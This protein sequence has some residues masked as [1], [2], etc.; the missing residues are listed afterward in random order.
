V[1]WNTVC[2]KKEVGGLG[3][4]R[5]R[6]F[7]NVLLGKWCWRLLTEKNSL[8]YRVLTGRY[9]EEGGCVLDGGRDASA[10]WRVIA[11]LQREPWFSNHVCRVV[12]DGKQTYFWSDVWVGGVSFKDRFSRLFELAVDKWVFVFDLC[13]LGWGVN[14]E[15][16]KWRQRLFAWEEEKVGELCLLL[17]YVNLQVNK[18]DTWVWNLEK[19]NTFSV[20]SAY[21][22][23]TSQHIVDAPVDVKKLWLKDVPLKV[24]V[25][26]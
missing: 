4:R 11:A 10:W 5:I 13:Q 2:L 1:D 16:W 20:C 23:Q 14:G 8:W 3:V 12:G 7:N 6:E 9:I 21:N 26:A 17:Q 25:F 19:S 22:F 24:V 18:E 15:A